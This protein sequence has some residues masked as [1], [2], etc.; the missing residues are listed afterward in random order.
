MLIDFLSKMMKFGA[1][2]RMLLCSIKNFDLLVWF[3]S[4]DGLALAGSMFISKHWRVSACVCVRVV[5]FFRIGNSKYLSS[6]TKLFIAVFWSRAVFAHLNITNKGKNLGAYHHSQIIL[7][8]MFLITLSFLLSQIKCSQ[9]CLCKK[10]SALSSLSST[11]NSGHL[12]SVW[13]NHN[14][15]LVRK[16]LINTYTNW[17]RKRKIVIEINSNYLFVYLSTS[18]R[19]RPFYE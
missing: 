1:T 6:Y 9:F 3:W 13:V 4:V 19:V 10:K 5:C 18:H 12:M 14:Q 16:R 17:L 11:E 8:H 15:S 7:A 2:N